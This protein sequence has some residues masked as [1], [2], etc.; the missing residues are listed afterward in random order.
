M[1]NHP[2]KYDVY[3]VFSKFFPQSWIFS[4]CRNISLGVIC[5]SLSF[6]AD[7]SLWLTPSY[8]CLQP[9]CC[10][11]GTKQQ[12]KKKSCKNHVYPQHQSNI[13]FGYKMVLN[14]V[15]ELVEETATIARLT[16]KRQMSQI[17]SLLYIRKKI[18]LDE[19]WESRTGSWRKLFPSSPILWSC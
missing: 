14:P 19:R 3:S 8:M 6:S 16:A 9:S 12:I 15:I 17:F 11:S 13:D 18:T 7:I 2:F 1:K 10:S 5:K 4:N